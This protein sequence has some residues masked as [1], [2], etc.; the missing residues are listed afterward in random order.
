MAL[1]HGTLLPA[2]LAACVFLPAA[3][4]GAPTA[5]SNDTIQ[6]LDE[7]SR[8]LG[9]SDFATTPPANDPVASADELPCLGL[10]VPADA[11]HEEFFQLINLYRQEKGLAPLQYSVHLEIAADAYAERMCQQ[12]FF[13]HTS[14]AGDTPGNRAVTAGFCHRYVGENLAWGLNSRVSPEDA[15]AHLLASKPHRDNIL[16]EE[17]RYVGV[18]VWAKSDEL[19]DWFWWVQLFAI[20]VDE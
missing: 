4:C 16:V 2:I 15:M 10:G 17:Y 14:P 9:G 20:D 5:A 19:G 8:V 13:D 11:V 7:A 1:R 12:D 6:G 18:G 3:G